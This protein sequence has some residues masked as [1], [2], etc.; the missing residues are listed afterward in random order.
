V[1][2]AS[3]SRTLA[4]FGV[5]IDWPWYLANCVGIADHVL[6]PRFGVGDPPGLVA[7][8]QQRFRQALEQSP[9]FLESTAAFVKELAESYRLAVVSSSFR[10]EVEPPLV[11]AGL[12]RCFQTILCGDGV[13]RVKPAPD[14]YLKAAEILSA[15][16]PLVIEDSDAGVASARSAGFDFVRVTGPSEMIAQV[17]RHLAL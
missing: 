13:T 5:S 16:N 12:D 9:P 17:R 3:W 10:A 15:S 8:K 6:A 2:F 11:R 14:P 7:A 4:P 1:H